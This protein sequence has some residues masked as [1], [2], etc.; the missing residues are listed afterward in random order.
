MRIVWSE[1]RRSYREPGL[2]ARAERS[3]DAGVDTGAAG[4]LAAIAAIAEPRLLALAAAEGIAYEEATLALAP[5]GDR[6]HDCLFAPLERG[7]AGD[8]RLAHVTARARPS[9]TREEADQDRVEWRVRFGEDGRPRVEAEER[10]PG[11][12]AE[13]VRG[14]AA[15]LPLRERLDRLR[16]A[17]EAGAGGGAARE[18]AWRGAGGSEVLFKRRP[19]L[20]AI[21][22]SLPTLPPPLAAEAERLASALEA[23][24]APALED[25]AWLPALAARKGSLAKLA[26]GY[27]C[28]RCGGAAAA[29]RPAQEIAERRFDTRQGGLWGEAGTAFLCAAGHELA[30]VV[31][32][33]T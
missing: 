2:F 32:A 8:P 23:G 21:A 28:S 26:A 11:R 12:R 24:A 7:A 33:R 3:L 18:I 16:A 5:D 30:R 25:P 15:A 14:R 10:R 13:A 17:A 9:G 22:E 6:R 1:V 27:R 20:A 31:D 29:P 19:L 4:G